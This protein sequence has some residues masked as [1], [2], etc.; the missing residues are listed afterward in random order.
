MKTLR[1]Y[2]AGRWHEA[3]TGFRTLVDPCSEEPIAR[4][5]SAGL[6][7]AAALDAAR[8]AGAELRR[9]GLAERGE[10]LG[11]ASAALHAHRDE[12]IQLSLE[13]SGTT[14][15][16]GKFDVDGATGTLAYYAGL[17]K[18]LGSA[19]HL[20]DGEGVAL[21][22]SPR[23]WGRHVR[24]PLQGIAVH[25]NAFNFPAWGFAEKAAC[26]I[27]AGMPVLTKPATSSALVTERAVE[28]LIE[29]AVFP[30][31]CLSLVCGGTGDLFDRLGPQDVVAFTGSARTAR[32]LRANA[33][34]VDAG[35]RF[36]VEADSLNAALLA[37]DVE[38]GSETWGAFVRDVTREITQKSGQKCTAV[39]R[40]L[41][42]DAR[43]AD[44]E[45]ALVAE[46][47]R[48][49]VG[50]PRDETVTLGPL[51]TADQLQDAVDGVKRLRESARLVHGTGERVDGA[52]NPKG[53]GYFFGPVLLRADDAEG[54]R[55]IHEHE[56][57]A[58]VATILPFGGEAG[59][60]ADLVALGGGTLVTSVYTD[61]ERY[62][63]DYL[64]HG[65]AS[66]GRIYVGSE[67]VAPQL[68]GSGLALPQL[69]H[70]GP[71]RAGGGQELGGLRGLELYTQRVALSGD[72]AIL[73]R[74]G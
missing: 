28:I 59:A 18:E 48:A 34:L 7:F 2:V 15:R 66:T 68:L 29:A 56:V 39:R 63:A 31:G 74:L 11:R 8:V 14:R 23:Y 55:P 60:A 70:G 4:A 45:Q 21:G 41:V 32:T 22:R 49:V 6:D 13:N 24:V 1:C 65:G 46:L 16:D 71:G 12:L 40:I 42:P 36:N 17:G 27:L 52:G 38:P 64:A 43:V 25:V 67:K 3:S 19:R 47:G 30:S 26:A 33:R 69:M 53:R 72:K 44:V 54:A 51:A 5:S 10:I 9:L 35:T 37:P 50:N 57:F 58:P 20:A 73:E 62:L 61:D